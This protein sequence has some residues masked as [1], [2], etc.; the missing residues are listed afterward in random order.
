MHL[1]NPLKNSGG[2]EWRTIEMYRLLRDTCDVRVWSFGA[3][4]PRMASE[5]PLNTIDGAQGRFPRGGC[6]VIVGAY[7]SLGKWV[8][9]A[10]P[11]RIVLVYNIA[12]LDWSATVRA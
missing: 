12:H 9:E 1:V 6:L 4:S 2:S 10:K 5:A 11:D 7:F 3:A 8:L